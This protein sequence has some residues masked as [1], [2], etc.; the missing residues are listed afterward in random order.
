MIAA[1]SRNTGS[2][3]RPSLPCRHTVA[4]TDRMPYQI[5]KLAEIDRNSPSAGRKVN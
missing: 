1:H 4:F 5:T 2:I 3:A